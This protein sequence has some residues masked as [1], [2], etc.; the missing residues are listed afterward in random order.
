MTI[1]NVLSKDEFIEI[2]GSVVKSHDVSRLLSDTIRKSAKETDGDMLVDFFDP[3]VLYSGQLNH[4]VKTLEVMFRD[5]SGWISWWLFDCDYGHDERLLSTAY[6]PEGESIPMA[7]IGD[8]YDRLV[9][10]LMG[11]REEA[12]ENG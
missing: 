3:F 9:A 8:L 12:G 4:L 5:D 6:G 11:R 10:D 1:D 7:T 2:I